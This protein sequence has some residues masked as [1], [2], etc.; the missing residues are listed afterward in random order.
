MT[1]FFR[2]KYTATLI[3]LIFGLGVNTLAEDFLIPLDDRPANRLFVGQIARIGAPQRPIQIPPRHLLGRLYNAGDSDA[4]IAWLEERVQPGDTVFLS[5]DMWLYGGLVASRTAAIKPDRVTQ[6]LQ[7]L[8]KMGESGVSIHALATIPRLSLRTS[9]LQAPHERK[10]AR[11]AASGALPSARELLRKHARGD[12]VPFPTTVP[13]EFVVEYL[14]VRQRNISTI[15]SLVE[16]TEL[17]YLDSLVL[18]QD[19]SSK[20]GLHRFEQRRIKELVQELGVEQKVRLMSGIDELSMDMIAGAWASRADCSPKIRVIYSEPEAAGKIPPLES[21]PLELMVQQHIE[22]CGARVVNDLTADLDLYVYVP[23][24]KPWKVPGEERRPASEAFVEMVKGATDSGRRVAVADLSLV[25]RMDPFLAESSL[26]N[27]PLFELEGFASWNTPANTVGT[28][29]AQAVC[30]QIA[31]SSS[32]WSLSARLEAEKTHQAFLLARFIDDYVYQTVV[33]DEIRPKAK[34][35]NSKAEPL[36]NLFGPVGLDIRTE[37][38]KWTREL[39]HKRY[40]GRTFCLEPQGLEVQFER[41][42][43]EV[44]L[45]WP[46]TFEVE[47]RLDVRLGLTGRKCP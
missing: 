1:I 2:W 25:N 24:K 12:K 40:L 34:G 19:D 4:V 13:S 41:S 10:L 6:R 7:R 15:E 9:D 38:V 8:E 45:P 26:Q 28:V 23:Y 29:V 39:F 37:L 43:L 16:L 33:R 32:Q 44:V 46:R 17:G 14:R 11:W 35:L 30:H 31:S 5:M 42:K 21:L 3:F 18:G 27:L 20:K 36:L 22:L 47:A